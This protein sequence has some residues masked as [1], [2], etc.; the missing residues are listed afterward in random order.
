[1]VV[2]EGKTEGEFVTKILDKFLKIG[3]IIKYNNIKGG[4]IS[5]DKIIDRVIRSIYD[6]DA[7]TTMV[8][9]D[10]FINPGQLSI[11]QMEEEIKKKLQKNHKKVSYKFIP[12]LQKYEFEALIFSDIQVIN[13]RFADNLIKEGN[14]PDPEEI[15][16]NRPPSKTIEKFYPRYSKTIDGIE[17][18]K[19]I[20]K[21]KIKNKCPHFSQWIKQINQL[22]LNNK[23]ELKK[24]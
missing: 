15:N 9:F 10:K 13:E 11:E 7:I 14:Y 6:Y 17:I 22:F 12:Y 3:I 1:M 4:K 5:I 23:K 20:D 18:I 16:H 24:N 8:D 19:K 21:E 2:V